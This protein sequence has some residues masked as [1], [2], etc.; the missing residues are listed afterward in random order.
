VP[1]DRIPRYCR[2]CGSALVA[3][4]AADQEVPA[5]CCASPGCI[6]GVTYHHDGP[7]LMVLAFIF[8]EGH[9]LLMQRGVAP[10]AGRWAPPG[11]FVEPYESAEAAA[12]RETIEEV[13][14]RLEP[15]LLIPFAIASLSSINQF[16]VAFLA[17][18][19]AMVEPR[20]RAP[21][22]LDARWFPEQAFPMKEIWEPSFDFDMVAVFER[23]R[24][25]RFEFFQRTDQFLRMISDGQRVTYIQRHDGPWPKQGQSRNLPAYQWTRDLRG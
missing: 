20:P 10:Y 7:A 23:L 1:P 21:E 3:S 13:G 18:L 15:E 17:R 22:A 8:A 4:A 9:M 11:G 25:G 14:I 2:F 5:S 24:A 19:E 12:I 6:G 16:Y